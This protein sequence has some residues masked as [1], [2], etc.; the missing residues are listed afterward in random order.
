ASRPRLLVPACSS[1]RR[2][3]PSTSVAS[4]LSTT[5]VPSKN[6]APFAGAV[7]ATLGG[8]LLT[9][10]VTTAELLLPCQLSLARARSW[11]TPRRTLRS[12]GRRVGQACGPGWR[13]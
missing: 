4:A 2:S 11:N 8:V 7:R 1:V 13:L 9:L 10:I 12:E 5:L 3:V 6:T